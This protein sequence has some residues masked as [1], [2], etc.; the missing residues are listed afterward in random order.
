MYEIVHQKPTT[1]GWTLKQ[2]DYDL[3]TKDEAWEIVRELN[4]ASIDSD[5]P[6]RWTII[7]VDY[8]GRPLRI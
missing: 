5:Q 3:M 1:T 4:E 6:D 2:T 8:N 7:P